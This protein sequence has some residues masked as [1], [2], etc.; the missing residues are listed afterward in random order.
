MPI[1]EL[2]FIGMS[3]FKINAVAKMHLNKLK[4][5]YYICFDNHQPIK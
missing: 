2:G 3:L 1:F 4:Y 5:D